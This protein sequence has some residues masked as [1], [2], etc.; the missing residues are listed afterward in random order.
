MP[1]YLQTAAA[2]W[3]LV[4]IKELGKYVCFFVFLKSPRKLDAKEALG[5]CNMKTAQLNTILRKCVNPV[6]G[7]IFASQ[8]KSFTTSLTVST[9]LHV[10]AFQD[11]S[12]ILEE[13]DGILKASCN[14]ST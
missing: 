1:I 5:Y 7:A 14:I 9:D 12:T 2:L 4:C 10:P 6:L 8:S 3:G 11:V 13:A